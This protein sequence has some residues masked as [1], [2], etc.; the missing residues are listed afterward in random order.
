MGSVTEDFDDIPE[1]DIYL[2]KD[3][4]Q[5][6]TESRMRWFLEQWKKYNKSKYL[7]S[8]NCKKNGF[9]YQK[10]SSLYHRNI[11]CSDRVFD[12]FNPISIFEYKTK[13]VILCSRE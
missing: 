13:E 6:W 7:L 3:V 12:G 1:G 9:G 8:I 4:F 5:H 10:M 2:I 11:D